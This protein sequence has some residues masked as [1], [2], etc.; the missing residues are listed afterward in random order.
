MGMH[1]MTDWGRDPSVQA[2]RKVF[3]EMEKARSELL[4][5]LHISPYDQRIRAWSEKSLALFEK[6]LRNTGQRGLIFN[7]KMAAALY[8]N[9]L[10]GII[11]SE[12]IE[13]PDGFLPE[14]M[15]AKRLIDEVSK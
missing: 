2:M 11:R 5:R 14:E 3:K 1:D 4:G 13:I 9:C 15:T 12:G 10:A 8:V 6:T 7:N